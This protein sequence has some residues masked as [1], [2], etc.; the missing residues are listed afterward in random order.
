[1]S[2]K[3]GSP[4][5]RNWWTIFIVHVV[6]LFT[7]TETTISPSRHFTCRW[8]SGLTQGTPGV[9][10]SSAMPTHYAAVNADARRPLDQLCYPVRMKESFDVV[11][12]GAGPTGLACAIE[13]Q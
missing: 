4:P 7:G 13:A 9:F 3:S 10:V 12:I 5:D 6:P 11:V 8:I 1:M 2:L